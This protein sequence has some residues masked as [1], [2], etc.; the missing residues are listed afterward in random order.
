MQPRYLGLLPVPHNPQLPI[1][2]AHGA[3]SQLP[4]QNFTNENPH[5]A[6]ERETGNAVIPILSL[7]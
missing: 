2:E 5:A 1:P 7:F 3:I 6:G 4:A